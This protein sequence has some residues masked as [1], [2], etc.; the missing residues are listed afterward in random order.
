MHNIVNC[1]T[2][3]YT[4]VGNYLNDGVVKGKRKEPCALNN[5]SDLLKGNI[6]S[7]SKNPRQLGLIEAIQIPQ[8][9]LLQNTSN[10]KWN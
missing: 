10:M 2:N 1:K 9:Q 7:D 6:C 3:V 8:H 4:E 5:L